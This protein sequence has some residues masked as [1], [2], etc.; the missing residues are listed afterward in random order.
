MT[1]KRYY[2]DH[3]AGFRSDGPST[4]YCEAPR[5]TA[6][7]TDEII[8]RLAYELKQ[9]AE[10][11][12]IHA[13]RLEKLCERRFADEAYAKATQELNESMTACQNAIADAIAKLTKPKAEAA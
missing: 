9:E 4:G 6:Q 12:A 5:F 2:E 3:G 1:S 10:S 7:P 13:G 11:A 8:S